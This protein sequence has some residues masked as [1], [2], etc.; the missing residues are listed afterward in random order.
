[1][2]SRDI[3]PGDELTIDYGPEWWRGKIEE[4]RKQNQVF[5]CCCDWVYCI[6]PAP[7]KPQMNDKDAIKEMKSRIERNHA[8]FMCW[9]ENQEKKIFELKN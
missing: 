5:F 2:N 6:N 8:I 4:S 1:L 9:K 7:G 3:I